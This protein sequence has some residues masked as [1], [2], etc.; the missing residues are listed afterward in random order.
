[1]AWLSTIGCKPRLAGV[2]WSTLPGNL[3]RMPTT[4]PPPAQSNA[5]CR[6]NSRSQSWS[7]PVECCRSQR[8]PARWMGLVARH[9]YDASSTKRCCHH[10][11]MVFELCIRHR[12]DKRR[13]ERYDLAD[14]DLSRTGLPSHAVAP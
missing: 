6:L 1:M 8:L 2:S 10:R 14:D 9:H 13:A 4:L 3:K 5:P 11:T 12:I 7:T